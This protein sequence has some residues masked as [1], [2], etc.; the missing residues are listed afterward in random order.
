MEEQR[1]TD[2]A[3]ASLPAEDGGTESAAPP[4]RSETAALPHCRQDADAPGTFAA[5]TSG[6]LW[7]YSADCL[8]LGVTGGFVLFAWRALAESPAAG[9]SAGIAY[10][11]ACAW[12]ALN[13]SALALLLLAITARKKASRWFIFALACAKLP[14]SYL[15]LFWLY[16]GGVFAP[17]YL[18]AG[19]ASLPAVLVWRGLADARAGRDKRERKVN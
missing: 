14:A 16:T 17:V 19:V 13:F 12:L 18:T 2:G 7:R 3:Q 4:M 6:G 8:V 1:S 15:L 11:V 9:L 5:F 10:A